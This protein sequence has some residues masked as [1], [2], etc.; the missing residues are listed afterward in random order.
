MEEK[1]TNNDNA[2]KNVLSKKDFEDI[3][4]IMYVH[5]V[6]LFMM[7]TIYATV[8]RSN[9]RSDIDRAVISIENKI[10]SMYKQKV[11]L[12]QLKYI[13]KDNLIDLDYGSRRYLQT[14]DGKFIEYDEAKID[15]LF[16]VKRDS[17]KKIYDSKM[18]QE[19][20][21]I[22]QEKQSLNN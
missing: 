16:D 1:S 14:I 11:I 17:I 6:G 7:A 21:K 9:F 3:V 15:S 2:E 13:N 22:M 18:N 19:L 8:I 5:F 4:K 12:P 10:D 20:D